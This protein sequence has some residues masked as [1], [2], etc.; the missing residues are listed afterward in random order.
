ME[1]GGAPE[2]LSRLS[3]KSWTT[4]CPCSR[5][6]PVTR[7][8]QAPAKGTV[9]TRRQ[10]MWWT[11]G[12]AQAVAG[13]GGDPHPSFSRGRGCG[14]RWDSRPSCGM[15]ARSQTA[16]SARVLFKYAIPPTQRFLDIGPVSRK[17]SPNA[18]HQPI[19]R[20]VKAVTAYWKTRQLL[21]FG[22][23]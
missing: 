5:C 12:V 23:V 14:T 20:S 6:C 19:C 11:L 21:P 17:R 13:R 16:G 4:N 7:A 22:L 8:R 9:R 10:S 2:S 1:G 3:C 18:P 15:C